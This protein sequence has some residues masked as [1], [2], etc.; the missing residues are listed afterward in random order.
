MDIKK[1]K[2]DILRPLNKYPAGDPLIIIPLVY[3][4]LYDWK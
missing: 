4:F 1:N 2:T 3:T